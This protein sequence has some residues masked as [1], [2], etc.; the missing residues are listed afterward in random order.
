[1]AAALFLTGC[2]TTR[3]TGNPPPDSARE[4]S[5]D[6][7]FVED[8][9]P[10]TL[11]DDDIVVPPPS[12]S[13]E[14]IA[15]S[16]GEAEAPGTES[17]ESEGEMIQGYR[18]QLSATSDESQARELQRNAIFKFSADVYLTFEG[19]LYKVRVG[20][21]R[22]REEAEELRDSAIRGGFRDAWIVPARVFQK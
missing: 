10:L 3:K 5:R 2:A 14:A 22:T 17:T 19:S 11:R 18:V 20:D 21:C 16:E 9:D 1:M 8:F 4:R 13:R 12:V 6:H 15:E 7:A